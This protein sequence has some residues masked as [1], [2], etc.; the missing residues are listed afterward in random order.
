MQYS[1]YI[2][3]GGR[4]KRSHKGQRRQFTQPEDLKAAAEKEERERQWRVSLVFYWTKVQFIIY[5]EGT[6]VWFFKVLDSIILLNSEFSFC[7]FSSS[8]MIRSQAAVMIWM[9]IL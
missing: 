5:G 8:F 6:S 9:D 1:V 3:G 4:G 7:H 2:L